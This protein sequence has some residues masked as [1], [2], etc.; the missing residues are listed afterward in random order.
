MARIKQRLLSLS[1]LLIGLGLYLPLYKK[2]Y[3]SYT[4]FTNRQIELPAKVNNS[5]LGVAVSPDGTEQYELTNRGILVTDRKTGRQKEFKLPCRFPKLSWG[6]D[7]AYDSKRDLIAAISFG[8]EGYFY[9]FDVKQRRWI[10]FRSL[11]NADLKSIAYDRVGDRYVAWGGGMLEEG[12]WGD[13]TNLVTISAD[14]KLLDYENVAA[15]MLGFERLS[16]R[17]N[18]PNPII[19]IRAYGNHI[20]LVAYPSDHFQPVDN[21]PLAIWRYNLDS[22]RMHSIT[23]KY[24]RYRYR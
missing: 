9:R 8:G 19:K 18:K 5:Q 4:Q 14:G 11:D 6:T 22:K 23:C 10:D 15:R 1:I 17:S 13:D 7:I 16:D 21:E 2:I 20:T 12:Y 24:A 3:R